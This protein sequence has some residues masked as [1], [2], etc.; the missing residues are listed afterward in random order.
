MRSTP[1]TYLVAGR[2]STRQQSVRA[3]D[4]GSAGNLRTVTVYYPE[5]E[6]SFIWQTE[7]RAFAGRSTYNLAPMNKATSIRQSQ[8]FTPGSGAD[9][10]VTIIHGTESSSAGIA[11]KTTREE[12][13]SDNLGN[14]VFQRTLIFDGRRLSAGELDSAGI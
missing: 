1:L 11:L 5:D 6:Q 12:S 3:P 9:E 10:R 8:V 2:K 7:I 4:Y 14:T 13:I